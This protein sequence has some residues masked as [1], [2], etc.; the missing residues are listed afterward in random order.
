MLKP[1]YY[2]GF[3]TP[4]FA[5]F[6]NKDRHSGK[7]T[8]GK[9]TL[10]NRIA[11]LKKKS[12]AKVFL[13]IN[14][15]KAI[16]LGKNVKKK[17]SI[18]IKTI[19]LSSKK[20]TDIEKQ[21]LSLPFLDPVFKSMKPQHKVLNSFPY[22]CFPCTFSALLN[23]LKNIL[24]LPCLPFKTNLGKCFIAIPPTLAITRLVSRQKDKAFAWGPYCW[25]VHQQPANKLQNLL[26]QGKTCQ[27]RRC[28]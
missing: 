5:L 11:K 15:N 25:L 22:L 19:K 4:I 17:H 8:W 20:N 18:S 23:S 3:Q 9:S 26:Q 24:L 12:W 7:S 14:E 10:A 16:F 27:R 1:N 6:K 21:K 13:S 2:K 28:V